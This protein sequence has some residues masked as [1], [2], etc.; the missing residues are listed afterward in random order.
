MD[1]PSSP[2]LLF[3]AGEGLLRKAENLQRR[4][5]RGPRRDSLGKGSRARLGRSGDGGG[6]PVAG[7]P[8]LGGQAME[9]A[10][11]MEPVIEPFSIAILPE[12]IDDLHARLRATRWPQGV[13]NS[14]GIPLSEM[15]PLVEHW[16]HEFDW[17]RR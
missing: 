7:E 16:L 1:E 12:A 14:G 13:T 8:P 17:K 11:R 15:R 9:E 5:S 3:E 2:S 6:A 4:R 10:L